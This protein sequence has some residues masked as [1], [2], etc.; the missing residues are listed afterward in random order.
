MPAPSSQLS[1]PLVIEKGQG[2][3]EIASQL[4]KAGLVRSK[5][6]FKIYALLK[7]KHRKIMA[8]RYYLE[9]NLNMAR[10][11]EVLTSNKL[12]K[13]KLTI[14]EGWNLR[15][16]GF[17]LEEQGLFPKEE[18]FEMAGF[19]AADYLKSNN[20]PRP[21]D[22]SDKFE[23]LKEKP[24]FVGLEGY[25][26]PDTY[27]ISQG[28]DLEEIIK[29]MLT[30]FDQK[31]TPQLREEIKKQKKTIFEIV[32]MASLIEK[33]VYNT[34]KCNNCKNLVAGILWKR[35]Q[36]GMPLQVDATI[37]YI[38][39]KKTRG[40]SKEETQID[41]PYNTYKYV[42]LPRGPIANPSLDSIQAALYPEKSAFWYYL[43][44]PEGETIFSRTLE[45]HNIAKARY[46][47]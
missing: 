31:L 22:F 27:F 35:Y 24:D 25:L 13:I 1:Q 17:Y 26:F 6:L 9:P 5:T 34:E 10:L 47:K 19:P 8:G 32:T 36:A 7:G 16:I 4:K 20:L 2:L 28:E 18:F 39:G 45:E 42:G 12:S 15:D 37:T 43:S 46:L 21:K 44:T 30:N 40:I 41:S 33:E 29:L 3:V 23:F 14:I 38:T 11:L